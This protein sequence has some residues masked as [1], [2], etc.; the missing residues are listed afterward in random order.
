MVGVTGFEPA[1]FW[2]RIRQKAENR[3]WHYLRKISILFVKFPNR[4]TY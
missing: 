4:E 1:T 3:V 2:S